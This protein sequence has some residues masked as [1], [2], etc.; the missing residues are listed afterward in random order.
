MRVQVTSVAVASFSLGA[1]CAALAACS[2]YNPDLGATPYLC[3]EQEP[4]CPADYA[5][6]DSAGR[7]VCVA[8]G[9]T[10]V[11]AG[12]DS[13]TGFQCAMDGMLEPNDAIDA[14]YQTDVGVGAQRRV[15]GPLSICPDGDKDH[16]QINI[17]S[18]N[19]GIEV[20]TQW[21]S[22]QP[23]SCAILNSAGTA[24]A[25][26]S[27][28][29]QNAIRACA[30]NLPISQYYAVAFSPKSLRNNYRIEMRVVDNCL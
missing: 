25:N 4:R 1:L 30:T 20:I 3:A 9:V 8:S 5:C 28:M 7:E 13:P 29:G 12:P 2:P 18:A 11:D 16:F 19:R 22:G 27:P 14:S 24:I 17:M 10:I 26:G 23:I 6:V 15:F 21:D